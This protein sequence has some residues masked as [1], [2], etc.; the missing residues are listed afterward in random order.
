[1]NFT[2]NMNMNNHYIIAALENADRTSA[3]ELNILFK[4]CK[5]DYKDPRNLIYCDLDNG[6]DDMRKYVRG[7]G[8]CKYNEIAKKYLKWFTMTGKVNLANCGVSSIPSLPFVEYLN[9]TS[10]EV[11]KLVG[12]FSSLKVLKCGYNNINEISEMPNLRELI[13]DENPIKELTGFYNLDYL[14]AVKM[15]HLRL[16]CGLENVSYMRIGNGDYKSIKLEDVECNKLVIE[17]EKS[18]LKMERLEHYN[19]GNLYKGP[20]TFDNVF[21]ST[22]I[23]KKPNSEGYIEDYEDEDDIDYMYEGF[24]WTS[25]V[26]EKRNYNYEDE[27]ENDSNDEYENESNYEYENESNDDNNSVY[28]DSLEEEIYI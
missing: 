22:I 17:S 28:Y 15:P 24:M 3:L 23:T 26:E 7:D 2:T 12:D 4:H 25:I 27:Y 13:I 1:V 16:V 18:S 14:R 8:A 10:N 21:I 11:K 6:W 9:I 5:V 20:V 19:R